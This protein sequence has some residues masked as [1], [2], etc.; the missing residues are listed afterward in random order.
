M[1]YEITGYIL[2]QAIFL[3]LLQFFQGTYILSINEILG[4]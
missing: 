4:N 2:S 3:I 1:F